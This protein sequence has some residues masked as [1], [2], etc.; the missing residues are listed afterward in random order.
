MRSAGTPMKVNVVDPGAPAM[1]MR[2]EAY[3]GA[4]PPNLAT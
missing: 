4:D 3:P 2:A 1:R